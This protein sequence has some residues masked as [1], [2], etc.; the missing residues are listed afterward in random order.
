M[1]RGMNDQSETLYIDSQGTY[2]EAENSK[3]TPV[4]SSN[5]PEATLFVDSTGEYKGTWETARPKL[6]VNDDNSPVPVSEPVSTNDLDD[7]D[8]KEE[9]R[10]R[11]EASIRRAIDQHNGKPMPPRPFNLSRFR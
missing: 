6:S 2:G 11:K 9:T 5:D 7:R 3:M 4:K 1:Q 8:R 10:R